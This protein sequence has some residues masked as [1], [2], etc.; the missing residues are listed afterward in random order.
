MPMAG[1]GNIWPGAAREREAGESRWSP[2]IREYGRKT[3]GQVVRKKE[4]II[5][6]PFRY[7]RL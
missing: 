1:C 2:G 6:G 5:P 3:I 4:T 7:P